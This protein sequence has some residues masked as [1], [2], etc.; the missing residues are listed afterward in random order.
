M[1][2]RGGDET[3][4]RGA[5]FYVGAG[6]GATRIPGI[7]PLIV[8]T[9][10]SN[11]LIYRSWCYFH[12][13][14]LMISVDASSSNTCVLNTIC[15]LALRKWKNWH[16]PEEE[17][18]AVAKEEEGEVEVKGCWKERT[19]H[20]PETAGQAW[21]WGELETKLWKKRFLLSPSLLFQCHQMEKWKNSKSWF[22]ENIKPQTKS[23]LWCISTLLKTGAGQS[24]L[25]PEPSPWGWS[26]GEI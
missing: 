13:V 8:C 26:W 15:L 1:G 21:G 4:S 25:S 12:Y 16:F 17:V 5:D 11:C 6:I 22:S 7:L 23:S 24:S 19:A 18:F 20:P 9:Q 3:R 14:S 2:Q 10:N